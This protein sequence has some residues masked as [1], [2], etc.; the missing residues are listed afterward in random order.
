MSGFGVF[1]LVSSCPPSP[2]STGS[3]LGNQ[4]ALLWHRTCFSEFLGRVS[5]FVLPTPPRSVSGSGLGN[6]ATQLLLR[7]VGFLCYCLYRPAD[8]PPLGAGGDLGIL[9]TPSVA[10]DC[11]TSCFCP[12]RWYFGFSRFRRH[13]LAPPPLQVIWRL[14][15]LT[16]FLSLTDR[17]HFFSLFL[18]VSC[19]L[20]SLTVHRCGS[21][22]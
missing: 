4:A 22:L 18:G 20:R 2:L 3:G 17:P 5:Y 19:R 10:Q 12:F 16:F 11:A 15:S 14:F 8:P 9:A 21:G 1:L 13:I 7:T 6:G